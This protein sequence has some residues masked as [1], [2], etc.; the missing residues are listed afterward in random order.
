MCIRD[1]YNIENISIRDEHPI[2]TEPLNI[3]NGMLSLGDKPGLGVDLDM[4]MINKLI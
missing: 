2:L 4:N 3:D 1:R